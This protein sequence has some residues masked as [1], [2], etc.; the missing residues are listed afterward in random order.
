MLPSAQ[1]WALDVSSKVASLQ[2]LITCWP[3]PAVKPGRPAATRD[4]PCTP[5][6]FFFLAMMLFLAASYR[7]FPSTSSAASSRCSRLVSWRCCRA[8]LYKQLAELKTLLAE[9]REAPARNTALRKPI[10]QTLNASGEHLVEGNLWDLHHSLD[11]TDQ[12]PGL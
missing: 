5:P 9:F 11:A 6:F 2:V 8:G 7:V 10:I 1:S 3:W 12:L 4:Q